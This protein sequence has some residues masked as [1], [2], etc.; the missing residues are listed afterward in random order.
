MFTPIHIQPHQHEVQLSAVALS[1]AAESG[2]VARGL[3]Y[4]PARALQPP[5]EVIVAG[6]RRFLDPGP[7][8]PSPKPSAASQPLPRPPRAVA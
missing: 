4:L 8:R 1:T 3:G 6:W 5:V 2:E 7:C